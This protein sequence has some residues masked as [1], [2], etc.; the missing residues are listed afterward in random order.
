MLS[1]TMYPVQAVLPMLL[2]AAGFSPYLALFAAVMHHLNWPKPTIAT[3]LC[4]FLSGVSFG[5]LT[6]S[7]TIL[8]AR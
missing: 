8:M 1:G 3:P 7:L 6:A 5:L 2:F 4:F